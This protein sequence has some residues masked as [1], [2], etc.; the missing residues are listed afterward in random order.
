MHIILTLV[1][2]QP[3]VDMECKEKCHQEGNTEVCEGSF[4]DCQED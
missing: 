4:N 3:W 1:L 2:M